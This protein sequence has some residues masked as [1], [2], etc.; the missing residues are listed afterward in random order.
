MS[1]FFIF[2]EQKEANN[3]FLKLETGEVSVMDPVTTQPVPPALS[4]LA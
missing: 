4:S 2:R 1:N 3:E